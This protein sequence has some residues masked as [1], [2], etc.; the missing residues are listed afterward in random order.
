MIQR[1]FDAICLDLDGTLITDEGVMRPRTLAALRAAAESGVRVMVATGR[2]EGGTIATL[3]ELGGSMPALVYNGAGLY[4][5]VE[6]RLIEERTLSNETTARTLDWATEVDVLPVVMSAGV[7]TAPLP[8]NRQE[9]AAIAFLEDLRITPNG[10]LPRECLMRITL[11]SDRWE[12]SATFEAAFREA[13]TTPKYLTHF[14]LSAL[15]QHRGS[16]LDVVDVQPPCRGKGEALRIL[17]ERYGVAPERVV[18]VGDAGNDVP[19]L[20][21]AGLAVAMENSMPDALAV[22][23]EVIGDNNSD[24]IAELVER[25]FL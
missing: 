4:C 14:P 6:G 10:D 2:S 7:K 9:E 12:D 8:R 16:A 22:A 24:A 13:V 5:P 17:E 3:Q 11:F 20:A 1:S 23:D 19:M 15:A 21:G 18:A 25:L